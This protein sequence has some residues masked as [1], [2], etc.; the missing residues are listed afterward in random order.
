MKKQMILFVLGKDRPG[1]AD[2]VSEYLF[3]RGANIEESRMATMAGSFSVMVLFSSSTENLERITSGLK[4]L[5][6]YGFKAVL[7]EADLPDNN[8]QSPSLP[9]KIE[10]IAMDNVGIVQSIVHMLRAN[11]V[12]IRNL[13]TD[14]EKAPLSG[15]PLFNLY[16]EAQ[17]PS[18]IPISRIK[19]DLMALA[20]EMNLDINFKR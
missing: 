16:L 3:N 7:N 4:E 18:E 10:V 2:D 11:N 17:V 12:N 15:A 14:I 20:A 8:R 9:L 19:E 5:E 1:I 13:D 6:G